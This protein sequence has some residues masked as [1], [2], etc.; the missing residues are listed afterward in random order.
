M[1]YLPSRHNLTSRITASLLVILYILTLGP[2]KETLASVIPQSPLPVPILSSQITTGRI[3]NT[4]YSSSLVP[5]WQMLGYPSKNRTKESDALA[6]LIKGTNYDRIS[7]YDKSA[8]TFADLS[9]ADYLE[10][11]VSYFIRVLKNST[12]TV[13]PKPDVTDLTEFAYDADGS[14][15]KKIINGVTTTTYIGELYEKAG[16]LLTKHIYLGSQR[17]ISKSGTQTLYYHSDHLGS[18]NVITNATGSQL[19]L[20]EYK[21][22][23]T[24]SRNEPA[25]PQTSLP[26]NYYFTGKELDSTGLYYYGARYYDPKVG[27]FITAD[28]IN[29]NIYDPQNLN[30]YSY[31]MNNPLRYIDPTGNSAWD[32]TSNDWSNYENRNYFIQTGSFTLGATSYI[33]NFGIALSSSFSNYLRSEIQFLQSGINPILSAIKTG[34]WQPLWQETKLQFSQPFYRDHILSMV[35]MFSGGVKFV[36]SSPGFVY[37]QGTFA[38]KSGWPGNKIKGGELATEH[39]LT[40]PHFDR[41]YGLPLENSGKP[42]WIIRARVNGQYTIGPAPPS[43]NNPKNIGGKLEIRPVN[44]DDSLLDWFHMTD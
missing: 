2:L 43:Y 5:G 32:N 25:N 31:C 23:G 13:L 15:V 19:Q 6:N 41:D 39:P 17:I 7:R 33:N 24:L 1:S 29:Q 26:V 16:S 11:G 21:P 12:W 20:T 35:M 4:S 42:D 9:P 27:R 18:S 44:P 38:N 3:P 37:R 28:P 22:Y 30:R 10:P 36:G 8:N 34:N 14:R 40:T